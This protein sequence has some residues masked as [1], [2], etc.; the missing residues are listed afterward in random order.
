M[1]QPWIRSMFGDVDG[2][3]IPQPPEPEVSPLVEAVDYNSKAGPSL[4][5]HLRRIGHVKTEK[6]RKAAKENLRKALHARYPDNPRWQPGQPPAGFEGDRARLL[7]LRA[8]G[9]EQRKLFPTP[10]HKFEAGKNS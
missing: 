3:E 6:K 8:K 10:Q 9:L 2:V 4:R 7:E 1:A 5:E